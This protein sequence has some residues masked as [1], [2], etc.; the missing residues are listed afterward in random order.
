MYSSIGVASPLVYVMHFI[1]EY[2][3]RTI[4]YQVPGTLRVLS[5]LCRLFLLRVE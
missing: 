2:L 1:V 5:N 3:V 4:M